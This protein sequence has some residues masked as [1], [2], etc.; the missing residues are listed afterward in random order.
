MCRG[1]ALGTK[2]FKKALI[3][4]A[5]DAS[6]DEDE[7]TKKVPRYDGA[8]LQ[9]ANELRWKLAL[10][11]CMKRLKK[12]QADIIEE[13]KSADWKILIAAVFKCKTIATNVWIADKLNM[14][15]PHAVSRYTGIF[16]QNG[17]DNEKPFQELIANITT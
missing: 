14:G 13:I 1:W 4:E 7:P 11:Q 17:K 12:N 15:A 10:E 6:E 3:A 8:T 5:A 2:D 9:E 16:K